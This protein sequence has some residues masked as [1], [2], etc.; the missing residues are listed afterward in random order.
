MKYKDGFLEFE[1]QPW[2]GSLDE[3]K[4]VANVWDDF[5]QDWNLR[6]QS[7]AMLGGRNLQSFWDDSVRDY[8]VVAPPEQANSPVK[9]YVST[10]SRDKADEFY[11]N[12]ALQLMY[13]QV[14][15]QNR[16]QEVD[17]VI[18]KVS[19][20]LL[21]WANNNDGY[22]SESGHLKNTR[23]IHKK[24]VE[25]TVHIM[26]DV[27]VDGLNSSLIPNEEIFIP[28]FWQPN[29][30]LQSHVMRAQLNVTYEEARALYGHLPNW[31]HVFPGFGDNFFVQR[32]LYKP[33]LLGIVWNKTMQILHIW[34]DVNQKDLTRLIKSG[35]LE[36]GTKRA[37]WYNI[38]INDVPML[39]VDT[40]SP[41]KDGFYPIT[42]SIFC[43]FAKT[44]FYWGNSLPNKI[45]YDKEWLD[46]WKTL[47][48][49][50]GKLNVLPPMLSLNGQFVDEEIIIPAKITPITE[51]MELKKVEG[52]AEPINNSDVELL[53]MAEAEI[54]RGARAPQTTIDPQTK[55]RSAV[56]MES[57]AQKLLDAFVLEEA[58]SVVARTYPI[59]MRLYQFLP[60]SEIEKIVIPDQTLG[61]GRRGAL[62]VIF[63]DLKEMSK[64]ELMMKSRELRAERNKKTRE[65]NP[66]EK[67][68]VDRKYVRELNF[69]VKPIPA[70]NALATDE[71]KQ[72]KFNQNFLNVYSQRPDLFNVPEA[73]RRF[74][75]NNEDD[76]NLL[77]TNP[78]PQ[79]QPGVI[80]DQ[81]APE[82]QSM[83][84]APLP[85][86]SK[87][88]I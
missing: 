7:Y 73:A 34:R 46:A 28:N 56:I 24:V 43:K 22:P 29:I 81:G 79:Q 62:E 55:A 49:Y 9:P 78:Q 75:E 3:N 70:K 71:I 4:F 40:L 30:Q 2:V 64:E 83:L 59:L 41:Y 8:A 88:P 65:G 36:K 16:S 53:K 68:F 33:F 69:Y 35:R 10:I 48:R 26:D 38:I 31:K 58:F 18:S 20:G 77:N 85:E 21:E 63:A 12:I 5:V 84:N 13:P 82:S 74:V 32:P 11:A 23:Y 76:E 86:L 47:L 52:V 15:A 42:K 72:E 67:V 61:N 66:S 87:L 14:I 45:R 60:K 54:D 80:E 57:N 27:S 19:R 37:K 1:Y 50:K 44:E 51:E 17:R 6:A 39:P 25:G